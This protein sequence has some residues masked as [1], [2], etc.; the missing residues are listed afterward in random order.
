MARSAHRGTEWRSVMTRRHLRTRNPSHF[1]AAVKSRQI[2]EFGEACVIANLSR[3]EMARR[4]GPNG[5]PFRRVGRRLYIR[6]SELRVF[7]TG[8]EG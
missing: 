6:P 5:E 7:L 4:L 1:I 3:I 2:L 8:Q